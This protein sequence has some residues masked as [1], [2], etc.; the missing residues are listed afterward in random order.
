VLWKHGKSTLLSPHLPRHARLCPKHDRL[1]GKGPLARNSQTPRSQES[2]PAEGGFADLERSRV[3]CDPAHLQAL[4]GIILPNTNK[5]VKDVFV[6]TP[7]A[8]SAL[9]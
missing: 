7:A 5:V 6:W 9:L 1:S 3:K 8:T 4:P 2:K